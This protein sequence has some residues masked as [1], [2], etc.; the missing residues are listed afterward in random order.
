MK[1][2]DNA[3]PC[4]FCGSKLTFIEYSEFGNC[5]VM[6]GNCGAYGPFE[7]TEGRAIAIWNERKDK[8]NG[9]N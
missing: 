3:K 9:T 4:P 5:A 6:C 1:Q 7:Y 8:L 2:I